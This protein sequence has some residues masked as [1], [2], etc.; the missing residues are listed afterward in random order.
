MKSALALAGAAVLALCSTSALAQEDKEAAIKAGETIFAQCRA[1][2]QVGPKAKNTVGPI[3]NGLFGRPSGTIEGY[4]Y[5]EANKKSGITWDEKEFAVY[6][7]NPRAKIPGTKMAYAGLK[8]PK[9]IEN[10]TAFL[11]NFDKD[12]N[13]PK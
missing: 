4:N 3:L 9:R 12:G 6:I 11:K 7:E 1:C 5:S 2:H 10:L 13:P 8:D